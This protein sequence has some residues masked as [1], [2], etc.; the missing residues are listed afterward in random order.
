MVGF[1]PPGRAQTLPAGRLVWMCHSVVPAHAWTLS[2]MLADWLFS[3]QCT[4]TS[5][6]SPLLGWCCADPEWPRPVAPAA[7]KLGQYPCRLVCCPS[8]TSPLLAVQQVEA[9]FCVRARRLC[10]LKVPTLHALQ[11]CTDCRS[12][13]DALAV[14]VVKTLS[15]P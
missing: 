11:V 14:M 15:G 7:A 5:L 3:W 4:R 1:D 9:A 10:T 12:C 6:V 2:K 8:S 13:G